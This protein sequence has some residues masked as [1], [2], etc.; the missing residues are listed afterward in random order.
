MEALSNMFRL[1]VSR[2]QT[3][4]GNGC[5]LDLQAV[6]DAQLLNSGSFAFLCKH[7][8]QFE[9]RWN[10]C[11]IFALCVFRNRCF[12]P[13]NHLVMSTLCWQCCTISIISSLFRREAGM[14]LNLTNLY[15]L[16]FDI[17]N[18]VFIWLQ[19]SL[20]CHLNAITATLQSL[21]SQLWFFAIDWSSVF[22]LW[23]SPSE[24]LFS[25]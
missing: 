22:S 6:D 8:L 10:L 25:S 17:V 15:F 3:L 13:R 9:S 19:P 20:Q 16:L 1:L 23:L 11:G 12:F 7:C 2:S 24:A 5:C 18:T 21:Q 14:P 4:H